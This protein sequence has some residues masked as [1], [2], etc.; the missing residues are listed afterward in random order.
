[1]SKKSYEITIFNRKYLIC[2][3]IILIVYATFCYVILE[4][5]NWKLYALIGLAFLFE[6][7]IY[8]IVYR[9]IVGIC[10]DVVQINE[11]MTDILE[12]AAEIPSEEYKPGEIGNLYTNLYKLVLALKQSNMKEQEEKIFLRDI[13]SDISHQL[14]TPLASLSVFL[15]LLCDGRVQEHDKQIQM[16]EESKNQI[17]RMEWMVL[18]MLKLAR[19]E[20]GAIQ[21]DKK[22]NNLY[23]LIK[24]AAEAVSYLVKERQQRIDISIDEQANLMCDGDWL[25]EAIINLLKNASDYSDTNSVITVAA[26][27]NPMYTRIYVKD[28][29]MGISEEEQKNIF[30]RFYRVNNDVNPNSVGIGLS[31]TKSIIEGMGGKISVRSKV[32]EYTHFIIT[33]THV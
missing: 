30:K 20:A 4:Q 1:M 28:E 29:G 23:M 31:L 15:E 10:R 13:I 24:E 21:F 19:I 22:S 2:G 16:L 32:G 17:S 5:I 27:L 12:Q 8:I 11:I 25:V 18:S 3:S 9:Q 14:K 33:F 6:V 7:V 26:E